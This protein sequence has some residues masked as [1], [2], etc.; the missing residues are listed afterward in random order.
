M[1][2]TIVMII[3]GAERSDDEKEKLLSFKTPTLFIDGFLSLID[4]VRKSYRS[5]VKR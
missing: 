2:N 4:N 1:T 3:P 5:R